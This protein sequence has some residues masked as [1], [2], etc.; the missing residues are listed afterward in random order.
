MADKVKEQNQVN[1]GKETQSSLEKDINKD[2]KARIALLKGVRDAN[3]DVVDGIF[4]MAKNLE[5]NF[6]SLAGKIPVVGKSIEKN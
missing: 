1:Q 4:D 6:V 2:L 3:S 5:K